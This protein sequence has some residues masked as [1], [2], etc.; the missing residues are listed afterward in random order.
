MSFWL[1][2]SKFGVAS[3]DASRQPPVLCGLVS[4]WLRLAFADVMPLVR[5]GRDTLRHVGAQLPPSGSPASGHCPSVGTVGIGLV[6]CG[7]CL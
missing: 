6:A 1:L 7:S 3:G 5:E 4:E 2:L